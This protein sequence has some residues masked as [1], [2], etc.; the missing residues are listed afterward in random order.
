ML[1]IGQC[2]LSSDALYRAML[3]IALAPSVLTLQ[4]AQRTVS[5]L[6]P[7]DCRFHSTGM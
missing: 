2:S 5:S 1:H 7:F 4:K 6:L 3:F